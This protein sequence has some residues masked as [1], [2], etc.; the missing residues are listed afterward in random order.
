MVSDLS[1]AR[2][3]GGGELTGRL[4]RRTVLLGTSAAIAAAPF[5]GGGEA[6]AQLLPDKDIFGPGVDV[7]S[8][9]VGRVFGPRTMF[10]IGKPPGREK[11]YAIPVGLMPEAI[12]EADGSANLEEFLPGDE[13]I[14][15]GRWEKNG[16]AAGVIEQT[17]RILHGRIVKRSENRLVLKDGVVRMTKETRAVGDG[18]PGEDGY[19]YR[20]VSLRK[21]RGGDV[22]WA[23][24][25]REGHTGDVI[26]TS[27]ST[28]RRSH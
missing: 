24:G 6:D 12:V 20:A 13:I 26:A 23:V 28:R 5:S 8:A 7:L 4:T 27:I 22:I 18:D 19:A 3:D 17:Y 11:L 16:L 25:R 9:V 15:G 14:I 1:V 21:L 2:Q 10:V